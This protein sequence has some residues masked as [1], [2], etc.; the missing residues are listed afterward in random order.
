[1]ATACLALSCVVLLTGPTAS[2]VAAGGAPVAR[3][4]ASGGARVTVRLP[5]GM[6]PGEHAALQRAGAYGTHPVKLLVLGDSIAMTL[7]MGLAG[8]LCF[9][10]HRLL[11]PRSG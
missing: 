5:P 8:V 11:V 3:A 6:S 9:V 10:F 7:G 2:T 1:M 4:D